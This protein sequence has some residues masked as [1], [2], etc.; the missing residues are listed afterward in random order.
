[1]GKSPVFVMLSLRSLWLD[2]HI[3]AMPEASQAQHDDLPLTFAPLLDLL[4][5]L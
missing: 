2:A 4:N 5:S 1:M 3:A